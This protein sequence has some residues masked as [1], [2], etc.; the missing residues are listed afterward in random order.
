MLRLGGYKRRTSA[1]KVTAKQSTQ[2]MMS[3]LSLLRTSS[4]IGVAVAG[5]MKSR[6]C[7]E[8]REHSRKDYDKSMG[9]ETLQAVHERALLYVEVVCNECKAINPRQS[10]RYDIS[11]PS[12]GHS[13]S[14]ASV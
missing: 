6:Y 8:L 7:P 9:I 10:Q 2:S 11:R 12:I 14:L 1:V 5:F 4:G 3:S 13:A